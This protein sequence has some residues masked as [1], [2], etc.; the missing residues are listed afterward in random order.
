MLKDDPLQLYACEITEQPAQPVLSIRTRTNVQD[1][2]Q[3]LGAAY[4]KVAQYLGQLGEAPAGPPFA[5]YY[6][7]D[8]E[9]LEM[10]AGFPVARPL[11]GAGEIQASV[12]PAGKIGAALYT[13]PYN[14]MAPAYEALTQYIKDQGCEPTGVSYEM[15]LNDPSVAPPEELQTR[16]VF[17]LK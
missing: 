17:P 10:E 13:G 2:P 11:P 9:N 8:M 15:Y 7:M 1:M 3:F 14:S 5:A 4:G 6:N 16:I 12:F